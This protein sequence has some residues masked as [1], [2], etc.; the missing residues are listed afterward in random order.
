MSLNSPKLQHIHVQQRLV[1]SGAELQ[2]RAKPQQ[3]R[4]LRG[5]NCIYL[6]FKSEICDPDSLA[7]LFVQQCARAS[8]INPSPP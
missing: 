3:S 4:R 8:A 2:T 7:P 5:L 6:T 1:A